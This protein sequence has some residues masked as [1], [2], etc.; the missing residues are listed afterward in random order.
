MSPRVLVGGFS[1]EADTF[2]PGETTLDDLR[3]QVF[4]V[5]PDLHRDFMGPGSE[6]AGAWSVLEEA[7]VEIVPVA[8]DVGGPG[9]RS[10]PARSTRSRALLLAPV[11]GT[12]GGIDGAYLMLPR[13]VRR[14]RRGRPRGARA[15][16]A[17][18]PARP[19]AA[20]RREPRLPREPDRADGRGRP[21]PSRPYRTCP[22]VDTRR[23]GEQ[24]GRLL[25]GALAGR[26]RPVT[27]AASRP[28]I[29]PPQLHD[30]SVDPF[31]RLM[32]LNDEVEAEGALASCLLP[33]AAVDRRARPLVEGGRD[34]RR[35]RGARGARRPSGSWTRRGRRGTSSSPA[36]GRRSTTRSRRRSRAR[37][38]S[39]SATPATPRTAAR[40]ATRR[41]CSA[42]CS[43]AAERDVLLSIRDGGRSGGG[44]PRRRGRRGRGGVGSG[45]P[46]AYNERTRLAGDR[47]RGLFDGDVV[48]THPVERR[49]PRG[50]RARRRCSSATGGLR[51]SCT[52]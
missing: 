43:A 3:A 45:A 27:A 39:S 31:R 19:R 15:R 2:A 47:R 16:G 29:T 37:P 50:H 44:R 11:D 42:P 52:R 51:S 17:P 49:L 41:S 13:L 34:R 10:R 8:R 18:R 30:S 24:A 26:V 14:A 28:M 21:T 4:G 12:G 1:M 35:R 23:T 38:R 40:S 9:R 6:L 20:D 46:G 5:G 22:H 48:Y 32:A 36:G 25:A 33:G 7:G